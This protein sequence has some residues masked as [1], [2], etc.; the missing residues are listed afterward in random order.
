M[1]SF[2]RRVTVDVDLNHESLRQQVFDLL[3]GYSEWLDADQSLMRPPWD[4]EDKRTHDDLVREFIAS[5]QG[6]NVSTET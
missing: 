4:S 2:G 1:V 5:Q 6:E 3:H